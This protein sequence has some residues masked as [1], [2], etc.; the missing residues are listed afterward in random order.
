[1]K[2]LDIA[3][4]D[5]TRS[6]R[7]LF[8]IGM[9]VIAPL[10]ITGLIYLAFG[11]MSGGSSDLP[12][13]QVG[14]VNLDKPPADAPLSLG[15]TLADMYIDPSVAS[16]ISSQSYPDEASA[17]AAVE[18]QQIQAAVI[19]PQDLTQA[20]MNNQPIPPVRILQDPTAL[21][22]PLV[23]KNMA[24]S[25]LDGI[26]GARIAIAVSSERLTAHGSEI[27]PANQTA[28]IN[29]YQEWFTT[30][31][32]DLFHSPQAAVVLSSPQTTP[33]E[34]SQASDPMAAILSQIMA[35]QMIFFAF[36]T[37]ANA[38]QSILKEE[39]EGTLA[40]LFT[41]P[42]SRTAILTGKFLAVV[43][44]VFGQGL[45]LLLIG[46]LLFQVQWGQ[47][48]SVLLALISQIAAASGLGV[49]LISL[50][51]DSRQAGPVI[52]GSLAGLGMLGGLFFVGMQMPEAFT[53]L[54]DFTPQGWTMQ[55]WRLAMTGATAVEILPSFLILV[56]M[57]AAMF[58]LGAIR[59]RRRFA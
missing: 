3:L 2:I 17:R 36:F 30:F 37:G 56:A 55:A 1:M 39:E 9:M 33:N 52:G 10:V 23:V 6:V 44:T 27:Q 43:L 35:G 51:K 28:L 24:R 50:V 58:I 12:V 15:K 14:V 19:A 20:L 5:F 11:G 31:Q 32:R 7:S 29:S 38:M 41:T 48:G 25:L 40:R 53:R 46:R 16:Y 34:N 26:N 18:A 8:A 22:G 4:N 21:I 45:V 57:G 49:L 13:I 42:T 59:F 54:A 47:P